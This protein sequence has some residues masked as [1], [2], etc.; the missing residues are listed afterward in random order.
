[1]ED[2]I[3]YYAHKYF[4]DWERIYDAIEEQEDIDFEAIEKIKKEWEGQYVTVYSPDYPSALRKIEKPPFVLFYK[5]NLDLLKSKNYIWIFAA[6]YDQE[7]NRIVKQNVNE[8]KDLDM[9]LVSGYSSEFER[10]F[11]KN[12]PPKDMIIVKD[13]GI[14]ST[15]NMSRLEEAVFTKDNIVV[16]EFPGKVIPSYY[17]WTTSNKIKIGLADTAYFVNTTL[18]KYIFRIISQVL[19]ERREVACY[20]KNTNPKSHN[21]KLVSKGAFG[22]M[23][24][25]EL[26]N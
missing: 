1:M 11:L 22:I 8:A 17:T 6:M 4:G 18:E 7:T 2:V 14:D 20:I 26:K 19:D 9:S 21:E 3:L 23:T 15:I 13:S 12:N 25:K 16:S 10:S 5:G 24:L